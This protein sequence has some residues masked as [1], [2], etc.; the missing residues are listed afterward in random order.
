[1]YNSQKFTWVHLLPGT[2]RFAVDAGRFGNF[3]ASSLSPEQYAIFLSTMAT[4][5]SNGVKVRTLYVWESDADRHLYIYTESGKVIASYPP[6]DGYDPYELSRRQLEGE[7]A[8]DQ[9]QREELINSL[10]P[11]RVI[12]RVEVA[13]GPVPIAPPILQ[14]EL[15]KAAVL[16]GGL[17]TL[18]FD[19]QGEEPLSRDV[20]TWVPGLGP[21]LTFQNP[22]KGSYIPMWRR[23]GPDFGAAYTWLDKL[24]GVGS[25]SAEYTD[26][27]AV[28]LDSRY[29]LTPF[30]DTTYVQA[31]GPHSLTLKYVAARNVTGPV[32]LWKPGAW[33]GKAKQT[34]TGVELVQGSGIYVYEATFS[35]L[36]A[37]TVYKYCF[38][39]S[40]GAEHTAVQTTRTW[41]VQEGMGDFRFI[42]YGDNRWDD[43]SPT[44]ND[45]HRD[46][47]C[48]GIM[49]GGRLTDDEYPRFTLHVGDL[50]YDG[51]D[52]GQWIPHFFRPAGALI[53]RI[54][55]FPCL[56]NH[57]YNDW[58]H[59]F[60]PGASELY[61]KLFTLPEN[62]TVQGDMEHYYFLDYGNCRFVVL[63]TAYDP[64]ASNP[65]GFFEENSNQHRWLC[66][67]LS[68]SGAKSKIVMIHVPPYTQTA[69]GHG[70]NA[71][72]VSAVRRELAEKVFNKAQY[73]VSLV[74]CGHNHF[75]ERSRVPREGGG[76][77]NYVVTGGGGAPLH[78]PFGGDVNPYRVPGK[79]ESVRHH[80]IVALTGGGARLTFQGLRGDGSEIDSFRLQ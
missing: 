42:A 50:V 30:L 5:A 49:K 4:V 59:A 32:Y 27:E 34:V 41:P 48:L 17:G 61:L 57:E 8:L 69:D 33:G 53:S 11:S 58:S 66:D 55:V 70:Y 38:T 24:E 51:I 2:E 39:W 14:P 79:A 37:D 45:R 65:D 12:L 9:G 47:A 78:N 52:P 25:D 40:N 28:G 23:D 35:G 67:R 75:Y 74:F 31:P 56:G 80:C 68:E 71:G 62:A 73:G 1:M 20:A 36:N 54:P 26:E 15:S 22:G 6:P 43:S 13:E 18:G 10:D 63:D 3:E 60:D 29:Y 7:T 77:V 44:F 16:P 72:D 46:V 21:K 64:D 76:T 19:P